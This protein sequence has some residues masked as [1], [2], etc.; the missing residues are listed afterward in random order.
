MS[1]P[2]P[3]NKWLIFTTKMKWVLFGTLA[4]LVAT[5][6]GVTTDVY[7]DNS[8]AAFIPVVIPFILGYIPK[9]KTP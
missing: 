3:E 8:W 5:V 9:E 1:E 6:G 4:A 2:A 7:G